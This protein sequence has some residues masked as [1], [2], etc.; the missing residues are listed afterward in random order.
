M[1]KLIDDMLSL[2]RLDSGSLSSSGFM[3]VSLS[4]CIER[5]V[6][7]TEF[8]AGEKQISIRK[9]L[10]ENVRVIGD[11]DS[12]TEVFLNIIENAIKYSPADSTVEITAASDGREATTEIRDHGAGIK[13][14]DLERVFDRFYRGDIARKMPG[15]GLG[16]SIA[17]AITEAHGGKISVKSEYG[18]GSSFLVS[19][20]LKDA[21]SI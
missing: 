14:E 16:L 1:K 4:E 5:A 15:T 21:L 10:Q 12:L 7:F 17:K 11:P 6:K 18:S 2:T 8:M 3:D 20:P 9:N 13:P 19:L